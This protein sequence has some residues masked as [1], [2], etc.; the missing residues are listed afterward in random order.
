MP[1]SPFLIY[2]VDQLRPAQR[3]DLRSLVVNY[4]SHP[5]LERMSAVDPEAIAW[6]DLYNQSLNGESCLRSEVQHAVGSSP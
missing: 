5:G 2:D 4:S 6:L 3:A 1:L